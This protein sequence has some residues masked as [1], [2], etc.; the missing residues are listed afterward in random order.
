MQ[1]QHYIM[2]L[3]GQVYDIRV[4]IDQLFEIIDNLQAKVK[5]LKVGSG[6]TFVAKVEAW[7]IDLVEQ[8]EL[9]KQ[10]VEDID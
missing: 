4:M 3:V 1:H 8:L 9:T 6:A 10:E 5:E 7:A 2:S